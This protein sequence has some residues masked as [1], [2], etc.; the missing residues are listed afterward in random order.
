MIKRFFLYRI[1][2]EATRTTIGGQDD[3]VLLPLADKTQA[4]LTFAKPAEPRAKIALD[5]VVIKGVPIASRMGA[6]TGI[7]AVY[8]R[9]HQL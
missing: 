6:H 3:P 5:A 4:A 2:T 7:Y 1:D 8:E 9:Q